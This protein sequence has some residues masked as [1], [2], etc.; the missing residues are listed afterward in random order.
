MSINLT[1]LTC[2]YRPNPIG[3]DVNRPRLSW[4]LQTDRK[5][6]RQ[7]AYQILVADS[8]DFLSIDRGN[9]WDSG[10][11]PSSNSIQQP[12]QGLALQ[13]GQ[14]Y[15]WKVRAWIGD[16]AK[17][18][19]W[20]KP[21]YWEMGLLT[22]T[23][24]VAAWITPDESIPDE[25]SACPL[26]RKSFRLNH[27]VASARLYVS[28]LGLYELWLNGQ[29]VGEDYFTPGWTSYAKRLQYQT[30][31]V[32]TL[33]QPEEN[34][35]GA[36]LGDG[37]YRGRL[38]WDGKRAFYG[39]QRAL[40]LQLH[41][42]T[43]QNEQICIISDSSWRSAPSPILQSDIY[44][45]ES[46]D[47]RL[48]L[49][50]WSTPGFNDRDWKKV[51]RAEAP[52]ARLV[53]SP[54]P[55]VRAIESHPPKA[56]LHR[57][58]GET[59]FDFGQNMVGW[60]RL[61]VSG[62]AGT[63][64]TLRHAEVLDQAENLYTDNL[65]SARQRVQYTLKGGG[66]ETYHPRFS[67]QGFRYVALKGY[68]GT[69]T[70]NSLCAVVLHSAMS[71]AGQFTCS[72]PKINQLYQNIVWSHKGNFLDVPTDCPQRDERLG[73]TGDAQVFIGSAALNMDVAGFFSKWLADLRADQHQNGSVP[74]VIPDILL[75]AGSS[76]WGD[77]ATIVPWTL[78]QYYGDTHILA[79]QYDSMRQWVEYIHHQTGKA[80]IWN[81]GFHFGDW[82]AGFTALP[83]FPSPV[84][85]RDLIA[86]AF[87]A[88]STDLLARAATVLGKAEDAIKYNRLLD[89]IKIAFNREFVSPS[90]RIGANT[91]ASYI[92]PLMFNLLPES[93]RDQAARRLVDL[94]HKDDDH[95]STG[96]V[97]TP[98]ICPVLTRF[99]YVDVAYALLQ[100]KSPPSWLY[101]IE[102]G[103]T[104]IWEHWTSIKPDGSFQD[105]SMNSF[106]H[107][108]NGAIGEWLYQTVAGIH[109]G[110]PGF[111]R[112]I[113]Q[114]YPG[115]GLTHAA[116]S[117]QSPYGLISSAWQIER[118]TFDL[119]VT[120]PPNTCSEIQLPDGSTK[121]NVGSG[122]YQFSCDWQK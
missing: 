116:A 20:S 64:L 62:E 93:K 113:I 2:E 44:D 96:F 61:K 110:A 38:A 57:P 47:A 99:G 78:Y 45:G 10:H 70:A 117:Y 79:E 74:H 14:R 91:Q 33:L 97:S 54:A 105:P 16:S 30:Y 73:W 102:H 69:P 98:Y 40:I 23:D 65:R 26:L 85:S 18:T 106:N 9:C 66:E 42:R 53:A 111:R 28:A 4:Q 41:I 50:G 59:I 19:A 52:K 107:Y 86:T 80:L 82:L 55:P 121:E 72:D 122:Y 83:L 101:A 5:N 76:A 13:A 48:E 63:T 6:V 100:Q 88:Y 46:Y 12:Y 27:P 77:A 17:P 114:P 118:E 92:L 104:T 32:T 58:N 51:V 37:W 115:G 22:P 49:P 34:T 119:K 103:A 31:D 75:E 29:R 25:S 21:A 11:V 87:F 1:H 67:F 7:T 35:L 109:L 56:I 43:A 24:W 112:I 68:P 120:I 3:L 71:P 95:L 81:T 39:K 94:I 15:F 90:G 60:V 108:A 36:I 8:E 89:A 84:T